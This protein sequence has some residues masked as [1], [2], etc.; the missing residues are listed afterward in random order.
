MI[1]ASSAAFSSKY[2]WEN[3]YV[4][5]LEGIAKSMSQTTMADGHHWN[6][7]KIPP[8]VQELAA[9]VHEPPSQYMVGEKDRPAIAGSDMPE[10]IPVVDLSRL[11]ASNGFYKLPL[12]EKQKYSNLVNG[13][14]FRIEGYGNDMVVSEKQILNWCDRFY[15]IVE[16]EDVLREY[17]VR[18]R[19]I[20][21][22][23][24]KKLAKLLGLS[25]GYL[26]DMFDEKAM[27]YARFNY[28]P[29]CP[30]PDNVFGLKPHSDA[31]VITIVAID[32]SVSGLQLL[33]QG[34]W[35]D[36]PIVPNALLINVGDGIEIMSN[37]LFKG[38]VHR[39]VTN[40]ESERV[41][42]AMFYTLDPE[43]ELEPVPELVDD[44][45]RPRQYVK[46]KTKDYVTGLFETLARGTRVIDTVKISDNLNEIVSFSGVDFAG[47]RAQSGERDCASGVHRGIVFIG[48]QRR[49][50]RPLSPAPHRRSY[51]GDRSLLLRRGGGDS[52]IPAT[53]AD[54]HEWKI[55]K[56]PPIVQELAA[57]VPEP[58]S[59]YVVDE[60]DRPA[61]TGSDMPEPIPVIDLSRLSASSSSDDDSGGELAKLRSALENWGLFLAVGH[62]IEPSF[63]SEVMKVTR[64]FYEL[65]LEEKQKYSNLANGNEFKHE[66]YGNDMVVSEKQILDWEITSLVLARLARLLGLREG[67]FVDMFDED[68]TTYARFNYYPRCLRPEDVLG[69]K[70]H[71]DGSV[72]TVVSV[73]DTVSGLQ[74]LRQGV[75]YDI[76]SNG[77]LKSPVHRV[78]TN[79]ERER[80][81]VV[82]FYALDPEK[83]LEP[84]PELVDDEKRPRQYAKMKIK[85]YLSGFYETFARGTRVIDTQAKPIEQVPM[86]DEP[87]RLPNIVQEL[88]AGVQEP[89]SRYL[90]DLAGGDQLAGAEI[91]E[92]IPTI[93]LGRLSG[94]DGADEAAKLRSALQ[95]WG[96]FLV[97]NHGV[98]TSLIDAVIEAAREFFRQPVEEKKKLSNL[99]DGKRFQIEGYGNDPVQTKDQILD[100]SDRLHL[101]VEPECDR[102]LAFWPTHPKSF[103]VPAV[104]DYSLLINIGVT[105]E[106]MTN[107]TFRAP[108][109]RVVT[110]AE[111]ERMSV[112]M[113]YAV[114]GE[115]EIE[116]VAELLGLK[117]QSARYRGIKGKD[118]LI[119]HYEHFSRGG[120]VVDSLKI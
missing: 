76:M 20:T 74:V 4:F 110:N 52:I 15:P 25:E 120:R 54:G 65:P 89:P 90:Q 59:Q 83:E 45:K 96:L 114:D 21:S 87:W 102:N 62:G 63:L 12:E 39:V 42:L 27:T 48:R 88:A 26:V 68:A 7:V 108:L 31:S 113:F 105:L 104:R 115:K 43:K 70:P 103:S 8:I 75:W 19:E 3:K 49:R 80:V 51:G 10:P 109:H 22:L 60:Q 38:P 78:V 53:M 1:V 30:R 106:I 111:R 23:V 58:P 119:G 56:I 116:P 84:A 86:A 107:G 117:Q 71:S 91:P 2:S 72:I 33:R 101:K 5:F 112:A 17:T 66:G 64:G 29:R 55:V 77:L 46:V 98:E 6:I 35:Y 69:L 82:M 118:L 81:S 85:D 47:S 36:V 93:D 97:S 95:N 18:C 11:S 100:W 67:Y 9:G 37:G 13:K 61:I 73:D 99:I 40:A 57:N 44:E 50:R 14:D 92:P 79:A 24:L 32:D 41:S 28:Y 34:V 94:S 16:P